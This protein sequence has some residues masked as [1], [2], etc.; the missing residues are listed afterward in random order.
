MYILK[1]KKKVEHLIHLKNTRVEIP[2]CGS[3]IRIF[4]EI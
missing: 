4:N 2:H 3:V 1:E